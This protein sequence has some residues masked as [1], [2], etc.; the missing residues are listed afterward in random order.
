MGNKVVFE[1]D[2]TASNLGSCDASCFGALPQLLCVHVQEGSGFGEVQGSQRES[3]V[4]PGLTRF[5]GE[6]RRSSRKIPR[7]KCHESS[8]PIVCAG[9]G[10]S[11]KFRAASLPPRI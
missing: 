8:R 5:L 9:R 6:L 2:P 1:K 7:L 10:G 4:S 3:R 11:E